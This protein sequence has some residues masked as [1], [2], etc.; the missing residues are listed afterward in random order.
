VVLLVDVLVE[1]SPVQGAVSPVVEHVFEEEEEADLP[2]NLGP[3][4]EG[5]RVRC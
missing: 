5:D 1:G 4:R 3:R 2:G